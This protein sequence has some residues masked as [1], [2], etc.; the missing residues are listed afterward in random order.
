MRL[1]GRTSTSLAL[2]WDVS[3]RPRAQLHVR[4]KLTYHKKV[5]IFCFSHQECP[6]IKILSYVSFW[7]CVSV[8]VFRMLFK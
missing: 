5:S 8:C 7:F 6:E 2:S 4:Y 3:P 1:V